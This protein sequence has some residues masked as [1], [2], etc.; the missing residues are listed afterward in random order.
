L[1]RDLAVPAHEEQQG[2]GVRHVFGEGLGIDDLARR[3]VV[4]PHDPL[5][6]A[7]PPVLV[8]GY[9]PGIAGRAGSARA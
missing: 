7:A 3:R 5:Q 8:A 1:G 4:L 9:P 6:R 2:L